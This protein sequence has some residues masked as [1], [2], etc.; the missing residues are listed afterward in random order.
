MRQ[1]ETVRIEYVG[2]K[3]PKTPEEVELELLGLETAIAGA[4]QRIAMLK[5]GLH[6]ST[7]MDED[8]RDA[9]EQTDEKTVSETPTAE[10]D[11]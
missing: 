1:V 7:M 8:V 3:E 2:L 6:L 4:H 10:K 9:L 5:Q 11:K